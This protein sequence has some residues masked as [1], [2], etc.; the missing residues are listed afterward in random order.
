MC[1]NLKTKSLQHFLNIHFE[2]CRSTRKSAMQLFL[3]IF[4]RL[5]VHIF[6][7]NF[8]RIKLHI[9]LHMMFTSVIE[10]NQKQIKS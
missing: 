3:I 1:Y 5:F 9:I 7:N 2:S 10:T 4:V 8:I 6:H